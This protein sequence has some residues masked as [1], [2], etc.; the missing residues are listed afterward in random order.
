MARFARELL[1]CREELFCPLSSIVRFA[2][3]RYIAKRD[4][5][6]PSRMISINPMGFILYVVIIRVFEQ[7]I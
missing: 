7:L 2:G 6:R 1:R 4:V 5:P 3:G